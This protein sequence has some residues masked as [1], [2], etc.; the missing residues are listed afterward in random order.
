MSNARSIADLSLDLSSDYTK[1]YE[2]GNYTDTSI[3]VGKDP[4]S[5]IFLAH[6]SILCARSSYFEHELTEIADE[7]PRSVVMVE[8]IEPDVFEILLR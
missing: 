2:N 6:A 7:V 3:H 4:N 5:K 8:D 1:L